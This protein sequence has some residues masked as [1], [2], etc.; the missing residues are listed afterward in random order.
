MCSA[1]QLLSFLFMSDL[2]GF[3]FVK[4]ECL[5]YYQAEQHEQDRRR[6]KTAI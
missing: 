3:V 4:F 2:P 6:S 5:R 1:K